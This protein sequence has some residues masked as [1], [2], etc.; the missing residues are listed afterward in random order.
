[1]TKCGVEVGLEVEW[2]SGGGKWGVAGRVR[3][4]WASWVPQI[5][6]GFLGTPD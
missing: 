6:L 3:L 5:D 4:F 1:M 2:Q